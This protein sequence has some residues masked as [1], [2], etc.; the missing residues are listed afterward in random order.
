[1]KVVEK[2]APETEN[3]EKIAS[4]QSVSYVMETLRSVRLEQFHQDFIEQLRAKSGFEWQ[5]IPRVEEN[6]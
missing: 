4:D 6:R 5:W 2:D 1:M 3:L